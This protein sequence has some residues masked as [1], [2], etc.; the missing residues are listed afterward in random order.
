MKKIFLLLMLFVPALTFAGCSTG[1]DEPQIENPDNP[2]GDDNDDETGTVTP[3]SGK[4]LIAYFSRWGNTDYPAEVD[5]STGASIRIRNGN[6]QGTTQIVAEYIQAAVGGNI[7]LIETSE[8]YPVEFDDVRDQNHAEQANGKLP[9]LKNRIE[10]M[11]QYETV[12]IGYPNWALNVPKL[13]FRSFRLTTYRVRPS[14][15]S[16]PT[17]VTVPEAVSV[18]CRM[19]HRVR[20]CWTV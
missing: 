18:P 3:G 6:R 16:V 12:F 9:A 11:D 2:G 17:T 8:P 7:H 15:R 13:F 4:I 1:G 20:G 5:A 14:Y 19:L 10:N